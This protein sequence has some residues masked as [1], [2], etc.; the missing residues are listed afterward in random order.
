MFYTLVTTALALLAI[1]LWLMV[2]SRMVATS[3]EIAPTG[4]TV[5][6]DHLR[7]LLRGTLILALLLVCMLLFLGFAATW[8]EWTQPRESRKA[9]RYVDAWKIAGERLQAAEDETQE[10]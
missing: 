6:A 1:T 10:Q 3:A 5:E 9:T 4:P 2:M 8:R 7:Q